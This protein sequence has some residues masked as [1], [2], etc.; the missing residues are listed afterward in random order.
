M[1]LLFCEDE[2]LTRFGVMQTTPWQ[3][4]GISQVECAKNGQEG[5]DMLVSHPD[6]LLTD[7]RMP[8]ITGLDIAARLKEMDPDSEV[9]IMSS[10]SDKEYLKKAIVLSTV[11]YIEKPL[12]LE[13]LK[14]ALKNA[15]ARRRQTLSLR[16]WE[17]EQKQKH[18]FSCLPDPETPGF[19]HATRIVLREIQNRY[20]DVN[21]SV[22]SLAEA[23]HFSPVYLGTSF[24]EETG[25]NIRPL[26]TAVRIEAACQL[27]RETNLPIAQIARQT[28][29]NSAN[30]FAKQFRQN[31][32]TTPNEYREGKRS[33]EEEGP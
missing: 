12:N 17:K 8:F 15:V 27:L 21:L 26:I 32:K 24:K 7:I 31:K 1:R 9:I 28:G 30:Y 29:F 3:E 10:Y 33:G 19:S 18:T 25:F 16:A 11:A 14:A 23:V 4:I 20:A 2:Y 5:M 22:D 13:E 6:I